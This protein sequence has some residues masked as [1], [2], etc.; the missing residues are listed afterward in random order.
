MVARQCHYLLNRRIWPNWP[1]AVCWGYQSEGSLLSTNISGR[2]ASTK[3]KAQRKCLVVFDR[4][5]ETSVAQTQDEVTRC[6]SLQQLARA[7]TRLV[8]QSEPT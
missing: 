4:L 1:E 8:L 5:V 3:S 6:L 7:K 2:H